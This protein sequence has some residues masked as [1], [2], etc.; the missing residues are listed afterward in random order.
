MESSEFWRIKKEQQEA[1]AK[2]AGP[3]GVTWG[4]KTQPQ[5]M[6]SS[7]LDAINRE[8]DRLDEASRN[9]FLKLKLL[10]HGDPDRPTKIIDVEDGDDLVDTGDS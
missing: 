2:S 5:R 1:D 3:R 4:D 7:N 8:W 9:Q 6:R 10:S